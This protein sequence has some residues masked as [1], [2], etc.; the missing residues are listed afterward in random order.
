MRLSSAYT[1]GNPN[2]EEEEEEEHNLRTT[3]SHDALHC[4]RM[5]TGTWLPVLNI[6]GLSF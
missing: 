1:A 5:Q 2:E 3:N 6:S 4:Q